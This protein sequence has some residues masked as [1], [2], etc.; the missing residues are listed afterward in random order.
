M[1]QIYFAATQALSNKL[2]EEQKAGLYM[3]GW[4]EIVI[5][6]F[7][8]MLGPAEDHSGLSLKL[9]LPQGSQMA[10]PINVDLSWWFNKVPITPLHS[11]HLF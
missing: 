4:I 5:I 3:R 2:P 9:Y 6:L 10:P 8:L 7:L 11:L 1:I